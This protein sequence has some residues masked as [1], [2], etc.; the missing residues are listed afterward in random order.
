MH[1]RQQRPIGRL[2]LARALPHHLEREQAPKPRR[3]GVTGAPLVGKGFVESA[4]VIE[5][6][7]RDVG[8]RPNPNGCPDGWLARYPDVAEPVGTC[9]AMGR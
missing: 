2:L 1:E 6:P 9:D 4:M 7:P 8:R 3:A 5:S